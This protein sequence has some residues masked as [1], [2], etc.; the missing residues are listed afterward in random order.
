MLSGS[1]ANLLRSYFKKCDPTLVMMTNLLSSSPTI[2]AKIPLSSAAAGRLHVH[3]S[4]SSWNV[5]R[6]IPSS[7][8]SR[9]AHRKV[10]R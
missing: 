7:S 1:F 10:S 8:R 3:D 5:T 9:R 4:P 6:R 2:A